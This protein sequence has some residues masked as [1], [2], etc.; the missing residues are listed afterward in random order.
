[1]LQL[2]PSDPLDLTFARKKAMKLSGLSLTEIVE[3]LKQNDVVKLFVTT[4][5]SNFS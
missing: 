2:D 4:Q 3:G 1:M 5:L